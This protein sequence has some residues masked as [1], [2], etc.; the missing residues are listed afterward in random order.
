MCGIIGYYGYYGY[1][2]ID[3]SKESRIDFIDHRWPD[4]KSFVKGNKYFLGHT[5]LSIQDISELPFNISW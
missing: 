2:V 3:F 4:N 1:Y 5:R